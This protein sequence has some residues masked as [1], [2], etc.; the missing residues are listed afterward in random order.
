MIGNTR[1]NMSTIKSDAIRHSPLI[2]DQSFSSSSIVKTEYA[3][4][5]EPP[6]AAFTCEYCGMEFNLK[7][8]LVGHVVEIHGENRISVKPEPCSIQYVASDSSRHSLLGESYSS[9]INAD[10]VISNTKMLERQRCELNN[11]AT[12]CNSS[13][14]QESLTEKKK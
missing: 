2:L 3:A 7:Q 4:R 6:R 5:Q 9:S 14:P 1:S 13:I 8:Y 11:T 12:L 10:I